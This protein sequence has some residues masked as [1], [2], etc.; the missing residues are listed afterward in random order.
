MAT[1]F[2]GALMAGDPVVMTG[3]KVP[4]V[5]CRMSKKVEAL[6]LLDQMGLIKI[7]IVPDKPSELPKKS[8]KLPP[9]VKRIF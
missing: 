5:L 6:D 1:S 7:V 2:G 3:G 9:N 8:S 4:E